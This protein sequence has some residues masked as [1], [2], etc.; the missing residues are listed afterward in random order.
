MDISIEA[1]IAIIGLFISLPPSLF[2]LWKI[3]VARNGRRSAVPSKT[4]SSNAP[5]SS[6]SRWLVPDMFHGTDPSQ[7]QR[8]DLDIRL[9]LGLPSASEATSKSIFYCIAHP[10]FPEFE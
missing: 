3:L 6:L 10:S 8:A 9:E 1:V 4:I 5:P 7:H 2:I